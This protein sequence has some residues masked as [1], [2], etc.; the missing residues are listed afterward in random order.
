MGNRDFHGVLRHTHIQSI[1]QSHNRQRWSNRYLPRPGS[2]Q[3]KR[4]MREMYMERKK[5]FHLSHFS[6]CH[7]RY[8]LTRFGVA[9]TCSVG[10]YEFF[11]IFPELFLLNTIFYLNYTLTRCGPN[12]WQS[13][14]GIWVQTEKQGC[15]FLLKRKMLEIKNCVIFIYRLIKLRNE[16]S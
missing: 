11:S 1:E 10:H 2:L 13:T 6:L 7:E 16:T 14:F 4:T 5:A 9:F 3:G 12:K 15:V 8:W